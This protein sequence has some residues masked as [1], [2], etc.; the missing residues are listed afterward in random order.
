MVIAILFTTMLAASSHAAANARLAGDGVGPFMI[1]RS[2]GKIP[3]GSL[4]TRQWQQDEN[5]DTFEFIQIKRDHGV[6]DAEVHDGKV[7]RVSTDKRGLPSIDGIEVGDAAVK[8]VARNSHSHPDI[9][10]GPT[11]VLISDQ[12]C[13]LSYVTDAEPAAALN[14]PLTRMTVVPML[15]LAKVTRIIASGCH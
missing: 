6:V 12:P 10:P 7:W 13:G 2:P 9:G 8:I 1:G 14:A 11:I 5:G 15:T 3:K 4:I